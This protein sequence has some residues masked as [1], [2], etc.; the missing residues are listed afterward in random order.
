VRHQQD[1]H[2]I[3]EGLFFSDVKGCPKRIQG[4]KRPYQ[5]KSHVKER[6]PNSH[7]L[8]SGCASLHCDVTRARVRQQITDTHEGGETRD[9]DQSTPR[10]RLHFGLVASGD[11]VMKSPSRRDELV[12]RERVIGF[13]MEGG[14]FSSRFLGALFCFHTTVEY[15]A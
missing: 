13:E 4:F 11:L 3:R 6:K 5:L 8:S 2:G 10:P 1:V 7:T 9:L 14:A 12:A 15:R